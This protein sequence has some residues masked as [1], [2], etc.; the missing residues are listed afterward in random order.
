MWN[1]LV[2]ALVIPAAVAEFA[3]AAQPG[4][5]DPAFNPGRGPLS[6]A[7]GKGE[8]VVIQ[9]DGKI[10][11]G[12]NFNGVGIN[13]VP[14][15]IRF[16]VDGSLDTT[17]DASALTFTQISLS[18]ATDLIPRAVQANGQIL[19]APGEFNRSYGT[20]A[21]IRL[22]ADGTVDASFNPRFEANYFSQVRQVTVLDSGQ[23]LIS[24]AFDRINGITRRTLA[25][26]NVDG[27]VDETFTAAR[28]G[29]FG[30]LPN[31]QLIVGSDTFYRLNADGSLDHSFSTNVPPTS[32]GDVAPGSFVVQPDGKI[33][34]S[35]RLDFYGTDAIRRLNADG[36]EDP[37]FKP[38]RQ[39]FAGVQLL[40][41]DGKVIVG[42][43]RLNP[44]GT[45]DETF[46]PSEI[47]FDIAQQSD[48]KLVTTDRFYTAPHGIRRLQLDGSLDATFVLDGGGLTVITRPA[49]DRAALLPDGRIA[50][51]GRFT[52]F[53]GV[54][55]R[56]VAVLHR[57][58]SVD[59]TFDPGNLF[60]PS[61]SGDLVIP[62]LV[63][64]P[65]GK[66]LVAFRDQ[67]L[68]LKGDGTVDETFRYT[69]ARRLYVGGAVL[70]PDGRILI[71]DADGFR[72]LLPD[73]SHDPSFTND[74]GE[75]VY[76]LFVEPDVKIMVAGR[77]RI[78]ARLHP[79]GS[80]DA[81]FSGVGGV[82]T[83]DGVRAMGRQ[84]DG[85]YLV[86]RS[87]IG[88]TK[89]DLFF[90]TFNDGARDPS[91]TSNIA[92]V[93][94]V[95]VDAAGITVAGE[96]GPS[97]PWGTPATGAARNGVTRLT[98]SGSRDPAFVEAQFNDNALSSQL[99]RQDDGNL[100]VAGN[101]T[102]VNDVPR[103]GIA[104]LIG[105]VPKDLAN[106][107]TRVRVGADEAAAI[108]GF[109]VGGATDKKI[110]VRALGPSLASSGLPTSELLLD[111]TLTL[112]DSSGA[113][114]ATNN[115]WRE[116]EAEV[117]A[118]GIPPTESS[119]SAIVATLAPG[120]YTAVVRDARGTG[121]G[122]IGLMEIYDLNPATG[123][124]LAN[125]STRGDVQEGENV[126]IGGFILR[127]TEPSTII[128]RA[129][130]P[131]LGAAG[132]VNVLQDPSLTLHDASG[133]IL[134]AN[135]DWK[136]SQQ[137]ELEAIQMG[138]ADDRES[139]L[140]ATLTAGPYTAVVRGANA[141]AG[142]ALVEVYRLE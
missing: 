131:S 25:R 124:T 115:D 11:V 137:A 13:E 47:G 113:V 80:M 10:I 9:S 55:R 111:P 77:Q 56:T 54:P 63:A 99:L 82:A 16:N 95:I 38:Y 26:L 37:T 129:V 2:R 141:G 22:N 122:G 29:S 21:L 78:A 107:S 72:R 42:G 108:G 128:A 67:L 112:H 24:G 17:F 100:I 117:S 106:I 52:H 36:S 34:Y 140:I 81:S 126:I 45:R 51:A 59:P 20:R 18:Q 130:G 114:I 61:P 35:Q 132:V 103:N 74:T 98:F 32:E 83:Y 104:R 135:D 84:Q 46:R 14:P 48:G 57:D 79:D 75:T 118:T 62:S 92:S 105:R 102:R 125:I 138:S 76:A 93:H 91:F 39:Q 70:Q 73:G 109:I 123:A 30:V 19:V 12:G 101:F 86:S 136:E 1:H 121:T 5:V 49:I 41:S 142:V 88:N 23:L 6:V 96:I 4:S 85:S 120:S 31:G 139:A 7:A 43:T 27:T 64:Q 65:D 127:G 94:R 119:E 89:T 116:A 69:P 133:A 71:T 40:Q 68:R 44:D 134:A 66:L 3:A 33:I 28:P 90:R 87:D 110:I 60:V 97:R 58:G 15:I 50:V 8:G 53:A